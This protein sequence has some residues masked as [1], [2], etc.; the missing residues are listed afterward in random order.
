M[1]E[2]KISSCESKDEI[3][4]ITLKEKGF[5]KGL[6]SKYKYNNK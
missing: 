4:D 5:I 2:Q 1:N 6:K 3:F